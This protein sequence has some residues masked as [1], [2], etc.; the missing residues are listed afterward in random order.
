MPILLHGILGVPVDTHPQACVRRQGWQ[1]A[2]GDAKAVPADDLAWSCRAWSSLIGTK[3]PDPAGISH[4]LFL[5]S[6]HQGRWILWT[7]RASKRHPVSSSA[8]GV[9][10]STLLP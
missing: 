10:T 5:P 9:P 8:D 1:R 3:S 6:A 2:E 7:G 4:S